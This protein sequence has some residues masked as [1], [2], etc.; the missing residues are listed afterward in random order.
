[1]TKILISLQLLSESYRVSLRRIILHI[2]PR[3]IDALYHREQLYS[4]KPHYLL[5]P[6]SVLVLR[7]GAESHRYISWNIFRAAVVSDI[8]SRFHLQS[9]ERGFMV[10]GFG[11]TNG[12]WPNWALKKIKAPMLNFNCL[13]VASLTP[14]FLISTKKWKEGMGKVPNQISAHNRI[15]FFRLRFYWTELHCSVTLL[16]SVSGAVYYSPATQVSVSSSV[17]FYSAQGYGG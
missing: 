14:S 12:F 3:R 17:N 2:I 13:S 11:Q 10:A 6:H 4:H 7:Q 8:I 15:P 1:M 9:S 16:I 5:L